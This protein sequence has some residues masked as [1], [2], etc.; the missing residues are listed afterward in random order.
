MSENIPMR[1]EL[2]AP[3]FEQ[4]LNIWSADYVDPDSH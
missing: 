2:E 1:S 3:Y 4:A